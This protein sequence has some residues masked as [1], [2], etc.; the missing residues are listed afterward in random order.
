[1]RTPETS[2]RFY[3]V[4]ISSAARSRGTSLDGVYRVALPDRPVRRLWV[5]SFNIQETKANATADFKLMDTTYIYMLRLKHLASECIVDVG[6][7]A[8]GTMRV[9]ANDIVLATQGG[10][11]SMHLPVTNESGIVIADSNFA[12]NPEWHL[13]LTSPDYDMANGDVDPALVDWS[14]SFVLEVE[15]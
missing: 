1:M 12:K 8:R 10:G 3:R 15:I 11:K 13:Y 7:Y 9:Y 4:H 2:T 5:E 6:G 14:A